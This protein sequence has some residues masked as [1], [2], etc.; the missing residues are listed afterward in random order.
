MCYYNTRNNI[1]F[2]HCIMAQVHVT[3][4]I[5]N[6]STGRFE[7]KEVEGTFKTFKEAIEHFQGEQDWYD[8]LNHRFKANGDLY[9]MKKVSE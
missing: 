3:H 6:L 5:F 4:R 2:K 8:K 7:Y 9:T 1:N